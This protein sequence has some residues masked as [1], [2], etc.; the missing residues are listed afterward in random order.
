MEAKPP[1]ITPG[2]TNQ[3]SSRGLC[4]RCNREA[5]IAIQFG[6]T[7]EAELISQKRILPAQTSGRKSKSRLAK[8]IV[9]SN[10]KKRGGKR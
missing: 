6:Q 1:C 2:C 3:Q 10:A 8:A 9:K 7:T 4:Q 5:Q